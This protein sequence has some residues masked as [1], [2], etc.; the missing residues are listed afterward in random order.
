LDIP[1]HI[2]GPSDEEARA[3]SRMV[4]EAEVGKGTPCA[5]CARMMMT[6]FLALCDQ[7]GASWIILGTNYFASWET[8]PRATLRQR[9]PTRRLVT[10]INLP[11]AMGL[12]HDDTA[13]HLQQLGVKP[14]M[15]LPGV[16]TNCRVPG[17]VQLRV[18]PALG[19]APELEDLSMEVMVGHRPRES[20]VCELRRK[21]P[22]QQAVLGMLEQ[23]GGPDSA[24]RA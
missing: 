4:A 12:T 6:R 3:F 15:S 14:L 2:L 1:L 16:S 18:A 11:Y 13:R 8:V 19:H 24:P 22:M 7:V 17:L 10:N 9:T 5:A 23:A 21:A 20:A